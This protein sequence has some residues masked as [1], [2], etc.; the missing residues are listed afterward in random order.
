VSA[1]LPPLIPAVRFRGELDI[2]Q[3]G[4]LRNESI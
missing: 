4:T 1:V 2:G 3:L